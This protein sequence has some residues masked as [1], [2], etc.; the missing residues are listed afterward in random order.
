MGLCVFIPKVAALLHLVVVDAGP[1]NATLMPPIKGH[2]ER[3][4][5]FVLAK[6]RYPIRVTTRVKWTMTGVIIPVGGQDLVFLCR[7]KALVSAPTSSSSRAGGWAGYYRPQGHQNGPRKAFRRPALSA[8]CPGAAQMS[9]IVV[10][11]VG[12]PAIK[13]SPPRMM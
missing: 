4:Y 12:A 11:V 1:G 10:L 2:L 8:T 5:A 3:L 13:I 6:P 9:F 7:S